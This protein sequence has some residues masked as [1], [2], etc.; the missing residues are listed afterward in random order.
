MPASKRIESNMAIPPH[1]RKLETRVAAIGVKNIYTW[2]ASFEAPEFY[3]THGYGVFC[4]LE[5]YY[6]SEH[7]RIGVRKALSA[8]A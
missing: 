3:K 1:P 4:E 8:G 2:T 7:G 6:P 5:N